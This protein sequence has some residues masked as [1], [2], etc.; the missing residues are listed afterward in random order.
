MKDTVIMGRNQA[1][2]N[3]KPVMAKYASNVRAIG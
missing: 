1:D 3:S 2:E